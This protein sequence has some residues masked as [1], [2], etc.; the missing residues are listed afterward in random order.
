MNILSMETELRERATLNKRT[1]N[2]YQDISTNDIH[3]KVISMLGDNATMKQIVGKGYKGTSHALEY[4]INRPLT[5][6]NDETKPRIVIINSY[7]GEK[8]LT[9][10]VGLFRLVCANGLII[11]ESIF[12]EK[13]RH[14]Q[15]QTY[16][17]KIASIGHRIDC[18]LEFVENDMMKNIDKFT[19]IQVNRQEQQSIVQRLG[20]SKRLTSRLEYSFEYPEILRKEDQDQN[21]WATYNVINEA[22]HKTTRSEMAELRKNVSLMDNVHNLAIN[23]TLTFSKAA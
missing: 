4:T 1:G 14:V 8:P 20:L 2:R 6:L 5:L 7:N 19:G 17:H 15:G 11:G 23:K 16:E 21:V 13:I 9:V 12:K 10:L 18:A 3:E 22:I